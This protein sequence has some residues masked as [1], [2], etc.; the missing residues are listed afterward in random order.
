MGEHVEAPLK[1]LGGA[2]PRQD[3]PV[4][5]GSAEAERRPID[6]AIEPR[7]KA[8]EHPGE[9]SKVE[10]G[11]PEVIL[12]KAEAEPYDLLVNGPVVETG[13]FSQKKARPENSFEEGNVVGRICV[14]GLQGADRPPVLFDIA[15]GGEGH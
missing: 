8:S 5:D 2:H 10:V 11:L 4:D 9:L 1:V 7:G 6:D 3:E 15:A 12:E 13:R 14:E